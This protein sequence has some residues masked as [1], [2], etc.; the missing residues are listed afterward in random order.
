MAKYETVTLPA[1]TWTLISASGESP[2]NITFENVGSHPII[3][4]GTAAQTAPT[5]GST[6]GLRYPVNTGERNA[7]MSELFSGITAIRVYALCQ[8]SSGSV[9]VSHA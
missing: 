2:T 4:L 6:A 9:F 3:V 5:A 7:A 1:D 8:N